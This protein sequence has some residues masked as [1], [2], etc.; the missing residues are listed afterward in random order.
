MIAVMNQ[1][2]FVAI[3]ISGPLYLLFDRVVVGLNL[4][5]S[6]LFGMTAAIVI[7]LAIVYRPKNDD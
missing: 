3:M 2:N 1:S 6:A 4:P 7:P 5:R